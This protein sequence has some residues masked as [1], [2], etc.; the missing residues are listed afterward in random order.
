MVS[1]LACSPECGRSWFLTPDWIKLMSIKLI[2]GGSPL[3]TQYLGVR[4]KTG[5]LGI[6]I[7]Y[8]GGATCLPSDS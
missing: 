5:W 4:S 7:M 6:K 3:T 1:R 2:I 8:P